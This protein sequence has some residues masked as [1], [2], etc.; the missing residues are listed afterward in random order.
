MLS[1]YEEYEGVL[2][3]LLLTEKQ[4]LPKLCMRSLQP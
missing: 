1:E 2:G 3:E 4:L